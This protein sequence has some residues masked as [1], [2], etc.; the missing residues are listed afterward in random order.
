MS[1][2]W[3]FTNRVPQ[4]FQELLHC[5]TS[6]RLEII[7]TLRFYI[8]SFARERPIPII[9][10]LFNHVLSCSFFYLLFVYHN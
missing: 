4:V 3:L 6:T 7:L 9:A 5:P 2:I 10:I 1:N 8:S